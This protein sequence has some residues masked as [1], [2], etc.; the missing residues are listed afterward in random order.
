MTKYFL[1]QPIRLLKIYSLQYPEFHFNHMYFQLLTMLYSTG[2][3][4]SYNF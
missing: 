3:M 2:C 4:E 1:Q